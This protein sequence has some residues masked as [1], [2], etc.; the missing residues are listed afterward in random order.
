[1]SR[2]SRH[3][4]AVG[5]GACCDGGRSQAD[6]GVPVGAGGVGQC[7]HGGGLARAC[8]SHCAH[9]GLVAQGEVFNHAALVISQRSAGTGQLLRDALNTGARG[10]C[11]CGA[12]GGLQQVGFEVHHGRRGVGPSVGTFVHAHALTVGQARGENGCGG[13]QANDAGV[14][15]DSVCDL[16]DGLGCA[17]CSVAGECD[18]A[19]GFGLHVARRPRRTAL[20][21]SC[22]RGTCQGID[23]E[24]M[25]SRRGRREVL[26]AVA[27]RRLRAPCAHP[28][29]QRYVLFLAA[30]FERG[31]LRKLHANLLRGGAP[32][33]TVVLLNQL[34]QTLLNA[35]AARRKRVDE[36]VSDT[37]NFHLDGALTLAAARLET[38]SEPL[39]QCHHERIVVALRGCND[40]FVQ[41]ARIE[42]APLA[43][44]LAV[45]AKRAISDDQVVVELRVAGARIVVTETR[46]HDPV[47]AHAAHT[48]LART[49]REHVLFHEGQGRVDCLQVR[50]FDGFAYA[51]IPQRPH[52]ADGFW[53]A[54]CAVETCHTIA[55]GAQSS[56][57][58]SGEFFA[59]EGCAHL[60]AHEFTAPDGESDLLL[61]CARGCP[62][63][64]RDETLNAVI[65]LRTELGIGLRVRAHFL[66]NEQGFLIYDTAL[67]IADLLGIGAFSFTE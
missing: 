3:V 58:V 10:R 39:V 63:F 37:G 43:A 65:D 51:R 55:A 60:L 16:R 49:R 12:F 8:G 1:M 40:G 4:E 17:G 26:D 33:L 41:C 11:R 32:M 61:F 36:V 42:G 54:E 35:G 15:H 45:G 47:H 31:L 7:F 24:S 50:F 64:T 62:S 57:D 28:V 27:R 29:G 20:F 19:G 5:K 18:L 9:D 66:A 21:Q 25:S 14:R 67:G 38:N 2:H 52:H 34:F 46:G 44:A 13:G 6:H 56:C 59:V 48:V 23:V 53:G 30:R 22:D